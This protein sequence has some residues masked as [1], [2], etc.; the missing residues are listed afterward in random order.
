MS[1][2]GWSLSAI[3]PVGRNPRTAPLC[4]AVSAFQRRP[5]VD[6]CCFA[7]DRMSGI[8]PASS[9]G[10]GK[11]MVEFFSPTMTFSDDR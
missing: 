4:A 2:I 10:T 3:G 1:D 5:G 7:T 6:Q 9:I 8:S 11:M